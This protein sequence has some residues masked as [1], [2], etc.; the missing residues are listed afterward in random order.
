MDKDEYRKHFE[1][2]EDFWWFAGRRKI[3]QNIFKTFAIP[4]KKLNIL[5]IGCGTGFNL[6]FF[7]TY[8]NSFGCDISEDAL[9]YCQKRDLKKI[10]CTDAEKLPYKDESFDLVT[11]LDV[12]YHK[13]VQNDINVLLEA[14][15]VLKKGSYLLIT[16][17]AFN[18][19]RSKHDIAFHT[20]EIQY[21]SFKRKIGE[22]EFFHCINE[23]FQF[24][25]LFYR[26]FSENY[27]KK[28]RKERKKD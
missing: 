13:N 22:G 28:R 6:K 9:Y 25:P 11:L 4:D 18:F 14:Y 8:G 19:L 15:R 26:C 7:Q 2:E 12:L 27:G 24:F 3:I 1:L 21:K 10:A 20:R 16:D 23:L 17:S 5:D